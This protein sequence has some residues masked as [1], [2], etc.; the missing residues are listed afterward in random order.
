MIKINDKE[1]CCG[2][3]ACVQICSKH[4]IT[5][6]SDEEGFYYPSVNIDKCVDCGLCNNVCPML[7]QNQ[8]HSPIISLAYKNPNEITRLKSSSGGL[9]IELANCVIEQH[10]VVFGVTYD[11]DWMPVHSYADDKEGI[12]TFM[13]SK[14]VQSRIRN[15]YADA[16]RFLREG[17]MVLFSGTPCQIAGLKTFLR[18][19][20]DN[21]ITIEIMCH[22]VPSPGI[23]KDYIKKICPNGIDGQNTVLPSLNDM[24]LIDGISFR[25]KSNG[26]SKYGFVVYGK[27]T[28][29]ADQNSVLLSKH[30]I[31][32]Q[33]SKENPYMQAFLSNVI[34]RPACFNCQHKSGKSGADFSIGD[35]WSVDSYKPEM[36]DDKGVT[37]AYVLSQKGK[38]F[39]RKTGICYEELPLGVEYNSAFKISAREKYP[40]GKF[41]EQYK[42]QGISCIG[43]IYQSTKPG[44]WKRMYIRIT[45]RL[46]FLKHK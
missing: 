23:W 5:M 9:F 33:W 7:N 27:S 24:P 37:L 46:P 11:A 13:G 44:F 31:I 10:G 1:T 28:S 14:Y 26:W 15:S 19:E 3:G 42:K 21:L 35:F 30:I 39:L 25:D 8:A 40:R 22:G 43:P 2:C 32:K 6:Q 4:C 16:K 41:W 12:K 18:K 20:Y 29:K 38:E 36:N 17:R 34:L 45:N